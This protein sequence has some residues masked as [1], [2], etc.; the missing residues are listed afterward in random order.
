M[1]TPER[2]T[3]DD[4]RA[5]SSSTG[6][7]SFARIVDA[8]L[9]TPAPRRRRGA[10]RRNAVAAGESTPETPAAALAHAQ[11]LVRGGRVDAGLTL[12]H[13][14]W[15]A[16][17]EAGDRTLMGI[18]QSAMVLGYHYKGMCRAAVTAGRLALDLIDARTDA[19]RK[20]H[21]MSLV[22]VNLVRAGA[23]TE[24]FETLYRGSRLLAENPAEPLDQCRFWTNA[25]AAYSAL[26]LHEDAMAC[27]IKGAEFADRI[28]DPAMSTTARGNALLSRIAALQARRAPWD[29]LAPLHT[30]LLA[31]VESVIADGR[32]HLVLAMAV[33]GADALIAT[34]RCDEARALLHIGRTATIA[35][36]MGPMLAHIEQRL[37]T[38]ERLTGHLRLAGVHAREAVR[39][40]LQ[41]EGSDLR[42]AAHLES[43]LVFEAQGHWQH[44]LAAHREYVREREAW[45]ASQATSQ[46][47]ALAA[48]VGQA[49][50]RTPPPARSS[51]GGTSPP[52]AQGAARVLSRED[53]ERHLAKA[54]NAGPSSDALVLMIGELDAAAPADDDTARRRPLDE[55]RRLG[56]VLEAALGPGDVL[57]DLD[58]ERF[59][60]AF[61]AGTSLEAALET[62]HRLSTSV[63]PVP[64]QP[65]SG[66]TVSASFGLAAFTA[67]EDLETA[68]LRAAWALHD[69]RRDGRGR[70]RAIW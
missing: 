16:V 40:A 24:A 32:R 65:A 56:A 10:S 57:S 5:D 41:Q 59:V 66:P 39:L 35:A 13:R 44:A 9:D 8:A 27:A 30:A 64:G 28:D 22:A 2:N 7:S 63:R 38:V 69:V 4:A 29:E 25:A 15:P 43:S 21:V 68:L 50:D 53:F 48:R 34:G 58:E 26:D 67:S 55:R 46:W 49:R 19:A 20:V 62:A 45:H 31:H 1:D 42:A 6:F 12:C 3:R 70:A 60:V 54:R 36:G 33:T 52:A 61:R 18:C 14:V 37:A 23:L 17:C 47:R 51:E 11:A